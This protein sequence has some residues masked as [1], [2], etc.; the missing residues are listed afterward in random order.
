MV[1]QVIKLWITPRPD[2]IMRLYYVISGSIFEFEL[3]EPEIPEFNA[4]GFVARE[5]G[6][7]LK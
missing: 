2:S 4:E 5:W 3:P 7:I 1:N 6:V